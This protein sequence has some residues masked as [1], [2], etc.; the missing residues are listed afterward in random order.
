M[1]FE[2]FNLEL[3]SWLSTYKQVAESY[4]ASLKILEKHTMSVVSLSLSKD[5]NSL[6]Y[7]NEAYLVKWDRLSKNYS[8]SLPL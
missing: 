2:Q 4:L 3:L 1:L 8:F 5:G 6:V 7:S